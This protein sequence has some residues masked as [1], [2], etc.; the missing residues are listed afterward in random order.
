[1]GLCWDRT[2]DCVPFTIASP[3]KYGHGVPVEVGPQLEPRPVPGGGG[4][5]GGA[6]A[7]PPSLWSRWAGAERGG[8]AGLHCLQWMYCCKVCILYVC[9][10]ADQETSLL[11][12]FHIYISIQNVYSVFISAKQTLLT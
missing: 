6:T 8:R 4:L 9:L 3:S 5:V 11:C 2:G 7:C 1:M 12:V 10:R